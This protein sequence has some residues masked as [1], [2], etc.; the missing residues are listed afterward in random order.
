MLIYDALERA[1]GFHLAY[2]T[3][4]LIFLEGENKGSGKSRLI[5]KSATAVIIIGLSKQRSNS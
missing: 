5:I 1:L 2:S 3:W 4:T